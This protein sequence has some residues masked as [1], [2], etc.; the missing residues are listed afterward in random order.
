MLEE[1]IAGRDQQNVEGTR[2]ARDRGHAVIQPE[3]VFGFD[4]GGHRVRGVRHRKGEVLGLA[5]RE[6]DRTDIDQTGV[7]TPLESERAWLLA[8]VV[9]AEVR[10][11][12]L[13]AGAHDKGREAHV[14]PGNTDA[15]VLDREGQAVREGCAKGFEDSVAEQVRARLLAR[16][17]DAGGERQGGRKVGGAI[18]R[19]DR[20]QRSVQRVVVAGS[21]ANDPRRRLHGDERHPILRS[22]LIDHCADLA[23]GLVKTRRLHVFCLHRRRRVDQHDGVGR[24][25]CAG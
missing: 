16:P 18:R 3:V 11:A 25:V 19:R 15:A 10:G 23:L 4:P 2:R 13:R 20:V 7:G 1:D 17:H 9:D 8:E 21:G 6:A 24:Q 12:R 22:E 5:G 14:L